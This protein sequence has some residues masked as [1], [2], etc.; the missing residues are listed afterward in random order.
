MYAGI[1]GN[2]QGDPVQYLLDYTG[3]GSIN[4]LFL[5]LLVSP[6]AQ[7][8]KFGQ[9][10]VLRKTL[11]VYSA[12]YV[13]AHLFVFVAFELQFEWLLIAS[14][15]IERPYISVGFVALLILTSLL[16]TSLS[17]VQKKMGKRWHQLHKWVYVATVLGLLHYIWSI[18]ANEIQP[19][20]YIVIGLLLLSLRKQKIKNFF[21]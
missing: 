10:I 18:K 3:I 1:M 9:L 19:I 12:I 8:C 4:L 6:L 13:L 14:E 11:G 21:K 15:V 20:I 7:S 16:F 5:S 17:F 2:L